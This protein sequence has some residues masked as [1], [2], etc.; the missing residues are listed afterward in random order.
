MV[1]LHDIVFDLY[2]FASVHQGG[3]GKIANQCGKDATSVFENL[4]CRKGVPAH[5]FPMLYMVAELIVGY[6]PG[7]ENSPCPNPQNKP[8]P[9]F[10]A[11]TGVYDSISCSDLDPMPNRG[12]WTMGQVKAPNPNYGCKVALYDRVYDLDMPNDSFANKHGRDRFPITDHCD[13][14]ITEAFEK[15]VATPGVPDHHKGFVNG[16]TGY[17]ELL[18]AVLRGHHWAP[19]RSLSTISIL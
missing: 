13:T 17:S 8:V 9:D 3:Q 10:D 12:S 18:P 15:L 16:L 2:N 5:G 14:D 19:L 4:Q 11:C 1:I 7:G 6:I